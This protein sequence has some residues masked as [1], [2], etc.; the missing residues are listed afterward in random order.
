MKRF[1]FFKLLYGDYGLLIWLIPNKRATTIWYFIMWQEVQI[2]I[3]KWIGNST[4]E[5]PAESWNKCLR[6][7]SFVAE[8]VVD[9]IET[10]RC[11]SIFSFANF[12]IIIRAWWLFYF[13]VMKAQHFTIHVNCCPA[14]FWIR[15]LA[16]EC[17]SH[18]DKQTKET[19]WHKIFGT[20]NSFWF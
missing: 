6:R 15:C 19:S 8:C 9:S 13:Y 16:W 7:N 5:L 12:V 11:I 2:F 4:I 20:M 1:S 10:M 18:L 3:S 14:G 17:F